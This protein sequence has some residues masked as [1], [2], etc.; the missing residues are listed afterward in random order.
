MISSHYPFTYGHKYNWLILAIISI[1]GA[2]VRHY[3]NLRNRKQ[4]KPWILPLA[5]IGMI[6]MMLYTSIPKI[7][8]NKI[9]DTPNEQ[10][11]FTEVQNIIK[12]RCG[13]C[14]TK[15]PTFEG[16]DSP[17]LGI[18]FDTPQDIIKHVEKIKSQSIDSDVM[19]P[20]NLSGITNKERLIISNW[21]NQGS[22]INN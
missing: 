13:V 15:N 19:P 5:A 11:S 21:I 20:G 4:Y 22:K 6:I 16:F 10:I 7:V 2:L 9:Q 14:H 1:L 12:Y 8:T 17:P 18:I 3:F